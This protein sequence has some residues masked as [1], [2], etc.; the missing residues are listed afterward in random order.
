MSARLVPVYRK[1][2]PTQ[3]SPCLLA[4]PCPVCA[5]HVACRAG[6]PC[7]ACRRGKAHHCERAS[8]AEPAFLVKIADAVRLVK[9]GLASFVHQN[10]AVQL[11]YSKLIHL[12]DRSSKVDERLVFDYAIGMRYARVAI[13]LGWG[14]GQAG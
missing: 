8:P 2:Q 6:S 1:H 14:G 12:R 4:E 5:L 3:V 11:N 7:K 10:S 13:D 9:N